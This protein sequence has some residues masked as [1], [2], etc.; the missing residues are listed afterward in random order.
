MEL[1]TGA[2][3][4]LIVEVV[5]KWTG[6]TEWATL[7]IL[8]V[9]SLAAAGV[10]VALQGTSYWPMVLQTIT[11]AAGFYALIVQRFKA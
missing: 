3:V 4:S 11:T 6:S 9:L 7:G 10:S 8:A 1:I 5:K 2:I